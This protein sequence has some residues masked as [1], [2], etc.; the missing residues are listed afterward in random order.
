M[1][2]VRLAVRSC[3]Y[4][5]PALATVTVSGAWL[6]VSVVPCH[7]EGVAAAGVRVTR[8]QH[9]AVRVDRQSS[10]GQAEVAGE[11]QADAAAGAEVIV[12]RAVGGVP[13]K[14]PADAGRGED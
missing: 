1:A 10:A 5:L 13:D 9:P 8:E 11:V 4:T 2:P 7:A 12:Q 3:P 6:T 14:A